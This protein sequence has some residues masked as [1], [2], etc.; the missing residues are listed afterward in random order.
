M[1]DHTTQTSSK[2]NPERFF[3]TFGIFSLVNWNANFLA[4]INNDHLIK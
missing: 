3:L 2:A 4:T 1:N